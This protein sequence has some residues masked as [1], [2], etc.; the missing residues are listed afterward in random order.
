MDTKRLRRVFEQYLDENNEWMS[1][2]RLDYSM[3]QLFQD[4][5]VR[6]KSVLE[7]GA[8][9]GFACVWCLL[10][11]AEHVVA[12]E[13]ETD[14]ST[15]GVNA[16]F[17]RMSEAI[18]IQRSVTYLPYTLDQYCREHDDRSFDIILMKAVI[19]HLDEEAVS[20]LHLPGAEAE[21]RRYREVFGKVRDRLNPGGAL[22]IYD[23]G[24]RNL[25]GNLRGRNWMAPTLD[26][27]IHQQPGT[28]WALLQ[29]C[30]FVDGRARWPAPYRLR[31]FRMLLSNALAA[32]FLMSA[33]TLYCRRPGHPA[34]ATSAGK[35]P[36]RE[37]GAVDSK[38]VGLE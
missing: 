30:G 1:L 15:G 38:C 3:G 37:R 23:V 4:S 24:R 29:Q 17:S 28:W 18:G 26:F 16:A 35:T 2:A 21:R 5:S 25:W 27:N 7:I 20:R 22:L 33:F 12:I 13:P 11:G 6:G 9:D 32:Y 10:K 34:S 31:N 36:D 19:N 8:G 14:G